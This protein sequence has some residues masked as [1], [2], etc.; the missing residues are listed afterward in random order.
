M[1]NVWV[2][3]ILLEPPACRLL[4]SALDHPYMFIVLW[5]RQEYVCDL[6]RHIGCWC[7]CALPTSLASAAGTVDLLRLF[8][9]CSAL[10]LEW[11]F[12]HSPP[13]ALQSPI[14]AQAQGLL[15]WPALLGS[16]NS[17]INCLWAGPICCCFHSSGSST[18]EH[19]V[20][21]WLTNSPLWSLLVTKL[22]TLPMR[23]ITF[24]ESERE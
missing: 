10:C 11:P 14:T 5:D 24:I 15:F 13:G 8:C 17:E 3:K 6:S 9:W 12:C 19:R 18:A 22:I 21:A 7:S 20:R 4:T 2:G 1:R 16:P 23:Y